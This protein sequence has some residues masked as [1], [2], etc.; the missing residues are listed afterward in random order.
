[1]KNFE[2][3]RATKWDKILCGEIFVVHD[4]FGE[5]TIEYKNDRYHSR[6]LCSTYEPFQN[7]YEYDQTVWTEYIQGLVTL[8]KLPIK[9]QR[10]W[11]EDGEGD[12]R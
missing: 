1:M 10:L 5:Y 12:I 7:N 3:G 6:S 11:G 9:F 4:C 8:Y 2:H